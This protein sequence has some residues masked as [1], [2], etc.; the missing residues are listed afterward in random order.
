MKIAASWQRESTIS[1]RPPEK[2]SQVWE[3]K[4]GHTRSATKST[5]HTTHSEF[6]E[7]TIPKTSALLLFYDIFGL[8]THS[9]PTNVIWHLMSS[10]WLHSIRSSL[11][12][13]YHCV[14]IPSLLALQLNNL[15]P[16]SKGS[17]E[18]CKVILQHEYDDGKAWVIDPLYFSPSALHF[19][20]LDIIGQDR[21]L[22]SKGLHRIWTI[23]C[24]PSHLIW[25][26][27]A[28]ASWVLDHAIVLYASKLSWIGLIQALE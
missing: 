12:L 5:V 21:N 2:R 14:L 18:I 22:D 28:W 8:Y 3:P 9:R 19:I 13:S 25:Q 4:Y 16:S 26:Q 24:R 23:Y 20:N 15:S 27:L 7:S 1:N 11:L 17:L 6:D 10:Q